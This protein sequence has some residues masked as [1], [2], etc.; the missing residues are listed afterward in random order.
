MLLGEMDTVEL[1]LE[2]ITSL[3]RATVSSDVT[4]VLMG[5]RLTA[6]A[7]KKTDGGVRG[8]ATGSS[9]R[10]LVTRILARQFMKEFESECAP[11]Q[12]ALSTRAGTD[13][14]GHFKRAATDADP[15][16]RF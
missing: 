1:L 12:Y 11:F 4:E 2:A 13:C 7:K 5:A 14:V 10:R 3:A 8:I 9:L 15:R 6:L 16:R